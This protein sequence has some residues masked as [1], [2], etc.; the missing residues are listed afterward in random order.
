MVLYIIQLQV[1]ILWKI[2]CKN[3]NIARFW[4]KNH[5]I[6]YAGYICINDGNP[7]FCQSNLFTCVVMSF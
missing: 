6:Y 4:E 7:N 3:M 5:L 1:F 2:K